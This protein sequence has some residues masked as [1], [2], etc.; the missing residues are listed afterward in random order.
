MPVIKWS[1]GKRSQAK[2]IMSFV[3]CHFN[4]W[5][6]PFVGG[7]SMLCWVWPERAICGDICE[8]L[9][10]LWKLLKD[11]PRY[12]A[13]SYE[14]R[15]QK[16]QNEG[17]T[18]YYAI[19]NSF[20]KDHKP[21]DLLFLSRTCVNGLIRFNSQGDF[22]NSFHHTRK[23]IDPA[24]LGKTI[25]A[26]SKILQ[27]MNFFSRDYEESL[28]DIKK[29]DLV[30]LDPPYFH[31]VGRYY[32]AIDTERFFIYLERLNSL[33]IRWMLSFDGKRGDKTY[34][35]EFPKGLARRRVMIPSGN[36]SFRKVIDQ[37]IEPVTESLY[38][39]WK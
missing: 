19:R 35:V 7:G 26:W 24:K 21:E 34:I 17:H 9:I 6:E 15:W 31:T 10:A 4:T 25:H 11:D 32:G 3:D 22:N 38:L 5:H 20:N 14:K 12:L 28:Y 1:G 16:L 33:D 2:I 37:K 23:G 30:Y 8:P 36:S 29:G 13:A 39:N 27:N 18:A